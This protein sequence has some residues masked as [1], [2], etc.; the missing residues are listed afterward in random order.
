MTHLQQDLPRSIGIN[1]SLRRAREAEAAHHTARLTFQDAKLLRLSALWDELAHDFATAPAGLVMAELTAKPDD[2][3]RLWVDLAVSVIMAPDP[4]TYRMVRDS[5]HSSEILCET[6]D[7]PEIVACVKRYLAQRQVIASRQK[8]PDAAVAS[9]T[10]G[11]HSI[12]VLVA[13]TA[14]AAGAAVTFLII[15]FLK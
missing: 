7:Q 10:A 4:R 14:F 11:D 15:N 3:P 2:E 5:E 12:L 8:T 1:E 13:M 9:T 6:D